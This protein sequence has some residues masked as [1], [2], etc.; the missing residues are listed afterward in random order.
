MSTRFALLAWLAST[1]PPTT[2]EAQ[3]VPQASM[4]TVAVATS[5]KSE[6]G[7]QQAVVTHHSGTF[8]GKRVDYDAIVEPIV[9]SDSAGKPA[10]RLV[11]IGYIAN[12]AAEPAQRPVLFVFNGGPITASDV[13]HMGALGPKRVAIPDDLAADSSQFKTVD[14]SYT[15]L[16]VADI[17]FFDPASTGFS[18]VLPGVAPESYFSV[19]A[20]AQQLTQFVVEWCTRH[21][22]L[23]SPK[24]LLGESYGTLRAAAAANQLQKLAAPVAIDGVILMGQ[25]LNV[26]EFSQRPV[27]VTS[28]VV[29]LPTLA[30]IAWSH[31]KA[32]AKGRSF[33]RFIRDV[34]I[35]ARTEYLTAL[36]R[37]SSLDTATRERV[38]LRLQEY[39]GIPASYYMAN[40]LRITKERYRRELFK[41]RNEV[42][43]TTDGRYIGPAGADRDPAEVVHS[44]F[45]AAFAAYLHG[46]LAV[47][48]VGEYITESPVKGL[49]AGSGTAPGPRR[50]PTGRICPC[51]QR[52]SL[53]IRNSG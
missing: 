17:V 53:P 23:G 32:E 44:A 12:S 47:E 25:A 52:C 10:A 49:G 13:L 14:N 6:A 46:D 7:P 34:E 29:S 36:F 43:G 50:S 26:I 2:I 30:A 45:E 15:V 3:A 18:R 11:T 38:A 37:G 9:V 5:V 35:F 20:D 21:H 31:H 33:D 51:C 39:T 27:N 8:N 16:D 24:Y 1:I 42:L 40:A 28:Y 48:D 41:E 22:R 19:T 4:P